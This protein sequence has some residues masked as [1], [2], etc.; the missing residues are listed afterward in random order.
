MM[1]IKFEFGLDSH[2][3]DKRALQC[4]LEFDKNY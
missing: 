2:L 4:N 3:S 1:M